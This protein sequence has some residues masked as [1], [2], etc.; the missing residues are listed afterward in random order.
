MALT[1]PISI[2]TAAAGDAFSAKLLEPASDADGKQI[3]PKGTLVEG[4]LL[5]VQS[6][7]RPPQAVVVL[8]PE[9]IWVRGIPVAIN[10]VR[11]WTYVAAQMRR[12]RK[13]MEILI[14]LRG[15]E[16]AG[17]FSFSGEHIVIPAGHRADWKTV[18]PR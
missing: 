6:Y 3:A 16:N 17:A 13:G 9:T 4:R 7:A 5:R 10:A 1:S 14:P 8:K 2:D 15:E 12:E 11:D 18:A